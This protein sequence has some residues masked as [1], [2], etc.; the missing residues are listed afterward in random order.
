MTPLIDLA[1][2]NYLIVEKT[3]IFGLNKANSRKTARVARV[4]QTLLFSWARISSVSVLLSDR[5][6]VYPAPL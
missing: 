6:T 2:L 1:A 5:S 3:L 4:I